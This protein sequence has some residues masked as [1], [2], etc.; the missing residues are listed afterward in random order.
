MTSYTG[1]VEQ[2]SKRASALG[3]PT[4]NISLEEVGISGVYAA[5][6][7]IGGQTHVAAAFAD[8]AR[9]TLE[10]HVLD[11]SDNLYGKEVVIDLC[12][13]IRESEEFPDDDALRTA[14]A[15]DIAKVQ[16]Y[17]KN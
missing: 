5:R 2:G 15:H 14:I 12:W 13:K 8:P 7:Q 1:I 6:V 4:I 17:F 11:F 9:K 3:Y 16:E 10:A